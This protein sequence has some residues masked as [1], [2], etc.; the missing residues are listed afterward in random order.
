[1]DFNPL[2]FLDKIATSGYRSKKLDDANET[3]K[4]LE[5]KDAVWITHVQ[6]KEKLLEFIKLNGIRQYKSDELI[7]VTLSFFMSKAITVDTSLTDLANHASKYPMTDCGI[8]DLDALADLIADSFGIYLDGKRFH[9][10]LPTYIGTGGDI[11]E[12]MVADNTVD[13]IAARV[14]QAG[15]NVPAKLIEELKNN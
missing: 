8:E 7:R 3:S 15:G 11:P 5:G 14:K 12:I 1:M 2:D 6:L 4:R 9:P 10:M 13:A